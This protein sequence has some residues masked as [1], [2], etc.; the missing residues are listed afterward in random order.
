MI[1]WI[2]VFQTSHA[3]IYIYFFSPLLRNK[4][5]PEDPFGALEWMVPKLLKDLSE[6][7]IL[8]IK[9]A[10]LKHQDT[11]R[12]L[13]KWVC[14]EFYVFKL[15]EY[16]ETSHNYLPRILITCYK[17]IRWPSTPRNLSNL[18]SI[19][20]QFWMSLKRIAGFYSNSKLCT[21]S[22]LSPTKIYPF[23]G[24]IGQRMCGWR[25]PYLQTWVGY[26]SSG[27]LP[28][29]CYYGKSINQSPWWKEKEN[30]I[31][32]WG[33]SSFIFHFCV[34]PSNLK[35]SLS[36]SNPWTAGSR[37]KAKNRLRPERFRC[38]W[39]W[40]LGND[41]HF[42]QLQYGMAWRRM[43]LCI[44]NIAQKQIYSLHTYV[45]LFFWPVHGSQPVFV[46]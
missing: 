42:L 16:I 14:V 34:T 15:F 5:M 2:S 13:M 6:A 18:T 39:G 1:A 11:L 3:H 43:T 37:Q 38:S 4:E 33:P 8:P 41:P 17:V 29:E 10:N 22:C 46:W 19:W 7:K 20:S 30:W 26:A 45:F 12:H 44:E 31:R 28:W 9:L 32:Q 40:D 24:A 23:S 25:A 36:H 27:G 35:M 21:I